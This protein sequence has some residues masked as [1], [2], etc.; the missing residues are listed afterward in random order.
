MLLFR[1]APV[2]FSIAFASRRPFMTPSSP[3]LY[4]VDTVFLGFNQL[5]IENTW[6]VATVSLVLSFLPPSYADAADGAKGT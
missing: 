5:G 1:H 4:R 2:F 6:P 3:Y